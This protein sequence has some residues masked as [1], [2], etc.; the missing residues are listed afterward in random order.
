MSTLSCEAIRERI[1]DGEADATLLAHAKD[2]AECRPILEALGEI[3][4][5]VTTLPPIDAPE[6]LV[7]ATLATVR[8]DADVGSTSLLA[9]AFAML[10]SALGALAFA[11]LTF[12][13]WVIGVGTAR[14]P[15]ESIEDRGK[16]LA[17]RGPGLA[18]ILALSS[19][20]VGIVG[21]VTMFSRSGSLAPTPATRASEQ[22]PDFYPSAGEGVPEV[23]NGFDGDEDGR[24][25][26]W[27]N[28]NMD[29]G[30]IGGQTQRELQALGY[31]TASQSAAH[32]PPPPPTVAPSAADGQFAG[33]VVPRP[34][35]STDGWRDVPSHEAAAMAAPTP[36]TLGMPTTGTFLPAEQQGQL[37]DGNGDRL[38][39]LETEGEGRGRSGDDHSRALDQTIAPAH[40]GLRLET[41]PE[42]TEIATD[43]RAQAAVGGRS[44]PAAHART[45]SAAPEQR[46]ILTLDESGSLAGDD[47]GFEYRDTIAAP[48]TPGVWDRAQATTG[49]TFASS[50]GWWA[51]TY[52]PGDARLRML[53]ARLAA[54]GTTLPG[55][56]LT[57]LTLAETASPTT[58]AVAPPTDRA[59]AIGV[60]AD[61]TAIEGPTRVRME[62]A[63]RAIEQASG[64]RG[65]LRVALVVDAR[66]PLSEDETAHLRS[67][68]AA[69]SRSLT[70]RD[71]VIMTAAGAHGGTLVPL[72]VLRHG[73]V[74]VA[75]R[76]LGDGASADAF[77]TLDA[78]LASGLEAVA[79]VDD[80]AGLALLVTPDGAHDA[81]VDQAL[82]LGA[83]AGVATT[84]V[85]VGTRASTTSLDAIALT[86]E[87]RRRLVLS[88]DDATRAVR[89]ELTAASRLV[90]RAMRVRV[91]LADGVQLVD[92][93]GSRA[94]N[95]DESRR[96]RES[97]R[98]IDL[99]LA[100][101][102]GIGQDRDD[103]DS[104][105]RILVPSFYSGD[106]HTIVLD[107]LVSRPGAVA[108]V[109]VRFKDLVR[110]GNGTASAALALEAGT[111][112]R[113]PHELRVVASYVGHEVAS[114]LD[115]A[116]DAMESGDSARASTRLSEALS[117]LRQARSQVDG[118]ASVA[119]I[120][121]DE[122]LLTAFLSA[123]ARTGD[124]SIVAASLHYAAARR[125]L[126]PQ[127]EASTP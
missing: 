44:G 92:V 111:A 75:L 35:G 5:L 98:A 60:H 53:H 114:A 34:S 78:A 7:Q 20:L 115:E 88:D 45:R 100:R 36:V 62:I 31:A 117:L 119:S 51:N 109:D 3:D 30:E 13:R 124:S 54:S 103:D 40:H 57:A 21:A 69:L 85:G 15:S 112:A 59:L 2:C 39:N 120:T 63:L 9:A 58:P 56:A 106:S 8:A 79:N 118:L 24:D 26:D 73:Q 71:R 18:P 55:S 19:V 94:L 42:E 1:A 116:G 68:L 25:H 91:H 90:A 32:S 37:D 105:I 22:A 123:T 52:V 65:A 46:A 27:W 12:V 107:L 99:S 84:A 121:T 28:A 33:L 95:A 23:V 70:P 122:S 10:M 43:E 81:A 76:H 64:R 4:E 126:V 29:R 38:A 6:A 101:R 72:S 89:E 41:T 82:H 113:G 102:L 49:L 87:G 67:L 11:P 97:E 104:G 16:S 17:P 14:P 96:T 48:L 61:T 50:E 77:T 47:Q 93:I 108:D 125:I 74:E 127:L 80:G 66:S 83:I 86:G 110:L